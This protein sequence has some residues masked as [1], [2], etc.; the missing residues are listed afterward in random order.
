MLELDEIELEFL[1]A[2]GIEK[3]GN[4]ILFLETI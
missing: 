2:M 4:F 3:K 1:D